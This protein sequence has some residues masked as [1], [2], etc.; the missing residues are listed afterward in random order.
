MSE[1]KLMKDGLDRAAIDRIAH[2]LAATI[3]RFPRKRFVEEALRGLDG[4]ELKERVDHLIDILH[5]FLPQPFPEAARVLTEMKAHWNRGREGD[6]V[7][8]FAAW[9][10]IDYVGVHGLDD[11][12]IALELL[13]HLTPLFTAEWAIRPFLLQHEKRTF[14]H[15][16]KWRSHPDHHVRRLVSEGT[17]PRLPWGIRLQPYCDDPKPILPFLEALKNDESDYVRRSVANNLN[18]ISKDHPDLVIQTCRAWRKG[19]SENVLWVIRHATRTLVKAGHPDVFGLLGYADAPKVEV[20]T[21]SLSASKIKVGSFLGIEFDLASTTARG[22]KI[23]VDYAVHFVKANGR[24]SRKVF[25]LKNVSLGPKETLHVTKS[26]SFKLIS[27][28]TYYPG[29]HRV[30]V[31]INGVPKQSIDFELKT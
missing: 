14:R 20:R 8:G 15:L 27:T 12:D 21:L 6:P 17:R 4:L 2:A 22:Q 31:Q 19:A 18:D 5:R 10:L 29:T 23:V 13:K 28:R 9:P 26:H 30:E 16:K 11:P 7:R 1:Q 24:T 25:K 3:K